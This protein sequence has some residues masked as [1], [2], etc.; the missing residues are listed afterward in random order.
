MEK[1]SP[2]REFGAKFAFRHILKI[3]WIFKSS[4]FKSEDFKFVRAIPNSTV[5]IAK[6]NGYDDR[7]AAETLRGTELFIGRSDLPQLNDNE[8]YQTDLIG[9]TVNQR[10]NIIGR[11]SC[12]QNYGAGD[13]L[14]MENGDMV[15]FVGATVDTES[16]VIYVK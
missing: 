10:G 6:I 3:Q 16:N 4:K 8:Y 9:M 5:V 11:V 14:E 7:N 13:I 2:P 1:L 15:S 12:I